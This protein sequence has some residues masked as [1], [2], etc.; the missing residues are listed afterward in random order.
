[1][2]QIGIM[3]K[4]RVMLVLVLLGMFGS[5]LAEE[6]QT[7]PADANV[8]KPC[9]SCHDNEE[10]KVQVN[11]SDCKSCHIDAQGHKAKKVLPNKNIA[12]EICLS[13]HGA[14][15][16]HA[17]DTRRMNFA[18]SEHSKADILC[19]NC[20]GIHKPKVSKQANA[21]DMKMDQNAKLCATCHQDVL[22]KFTMNSHHPVKEGGVSCNGCHDPHAAKTATLGAKTQACTQCHQAVAGPRAFEHPPVAE[23]CTTCHDPHGSPNKRLLLAAQPMQCIQC[24]SPPGNRHGQTGGNS[25]S[26]TA[27]PISGALLRDCVGC[28][29]AIHG[30]AVDM[31]LRF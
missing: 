3:R 12:S 29:N 22:A 9:T 4:L 10:A 18:F 27:N 11:H 16:G 19:S 28:H 26:N 20:H 2:K 5:A 7:A 24:H 13:C 8:D 21:A 15:K 31:H 1:M 17:K 14:G 25:F 23:D 6:T 30:S